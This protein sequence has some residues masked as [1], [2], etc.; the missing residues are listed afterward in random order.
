[1]KVVVVLSLGH[2]LLMFPSS[3]DAREMCSH[4]LPQPPPSPS[5]PLFCSFHCEL[6]PSW[7][8]ASHTGHFQCKMSKLIY[9]RYDDGSRYRDYLIFQSYNREFDLPKSSLKFECLRVGRTIII[10]LYFFVTILHISD[11]SVVSFL[12]LKNVLN[13]SGL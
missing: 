12:L 4:R 10:E 9:V 3:R 8:D 2:F 11:R 6:R 7:P 1:M 13:K 5:P